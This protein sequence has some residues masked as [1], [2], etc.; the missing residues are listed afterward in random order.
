[1]ATA[2]STAA[3]KFEVVKVWEW[4]D[5]DGEPQTRIESTSGERWYPNMETASRV[6]QIF[7]DQRPGSQRSAGMFYESRMVTA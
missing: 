4:E 7:N 3:P 5:A 1:M 6:A 2:T